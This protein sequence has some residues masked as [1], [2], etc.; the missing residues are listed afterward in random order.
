[1]KEILVAP[2]FGLAADVMDVPCLKSKLLV[3]NQILLVQYAVM[4]NEALIVFFTLTLSS[5]KLI[6]LVACQLDVSSTPTIES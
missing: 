5:S 4:E 6:F 3:Q 1:M 2:T